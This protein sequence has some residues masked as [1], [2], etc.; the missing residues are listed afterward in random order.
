[1]Q[2]RLRRNLYQIAVALFILGK[3]QQVV[4]GIAIGRS[5]LYVVIVLLA[6]VKLAA[7]DRLYPIL[8]RMSDEL[9]RAK[10]IAV[11]GHR[12]SRHAKLVH[13]LAKSLD[14]AG[15]IQQRVVGMQMQVDELGHSKW[16]I[17]DG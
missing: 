3:D 4:V 1:V 9:D 11:V 14:I 7:H 5:A 12:H 15:A 10:N 2:R 6:D 13:M 16:L 17:A 8:M